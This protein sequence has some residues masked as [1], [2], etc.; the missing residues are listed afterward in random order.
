MN[1]CICILKTSPV[2]CWKY[3]HLL[4]P[5]KQSMLHHK[6]GRRVKWEDQERVFLQLVFTTEKDYNHILFIV[7]ITYKLN[8]YY[9]II[10]IFSVSKNNS[11]RLPLN[12]KKKSPTYYRYAK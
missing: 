1:V 3:L 9:E 12:A 5:C 8:S 7:A 2:I 11:K 6:A 10:L 4:L